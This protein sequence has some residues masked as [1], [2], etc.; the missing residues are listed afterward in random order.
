MKQLLKF[1]A[2]ALTLFSLVSISCQT[3]MGSPVSPGSVEGNV[4]VVLDPRS[5]VH[6][7]ARFSDGA[8]LAHLGCIALW[9]GRALSWDPVREEFPGDAEANMLR[10]RASREPWSV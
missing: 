7:M 3:L 6:S 10:C 4:R 8:I 5:T 2:L 9:T 1:F